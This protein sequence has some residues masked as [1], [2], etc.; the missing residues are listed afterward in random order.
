MMK[1]TMKQDAFTLIEMLISITVFT[2]FI[3]AAIGTYNLF[4]RA[5]QQ[6]ADQREIV[7]ET[8][9]IFE[10]LTELVQESRIDF[11]RYEE[12]QPSVLGPIQSHQ[13]YLID[14][15]SRER[16]ELTWDPYEESLSEQWF[17]GEG[18]P[19]PG[20]LEPVVLHDVLFSVEEIDFTIYPNLD[21][22]DPENSQD[23]GLQFQPIVR[24]ELLV[25]RPGRVS[26]RLYMDLETSITSRFYSQR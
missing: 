13:L 19:S 14:P 2:I 17:V 26:E 16:Y 23:S 1:K 12:E 6:S 25:S 21:P 8:Q 10:H 22:Y 15:E 3:G 4:H 18:V 24:M 5:Q 11:E 7:Q 20:Y 9:R